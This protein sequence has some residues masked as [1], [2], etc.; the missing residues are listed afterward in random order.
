MPED[1]TAKKNPTATLAD[2][3][4]SITPRTLVITDTGKGKKTIL[5]DLSAMLQKIEYWHQ[6]SVAHLK[7]TILDAEGKRV[8]SPGQP[9]FGLRV[10]QTL[11]S[12]P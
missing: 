10:A 7:L 6:G 3:S 9:E 8:S 1:S 12:F 5:E 4:Y 2:F 11:Q